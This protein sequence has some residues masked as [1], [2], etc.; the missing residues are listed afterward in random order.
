MNYC[1]KC[2]M[3]SETEVCPMCESKKLREVTPEDYCFLLECER[4]FGDMLEE[5]MQKEA[6]QCALVPCGTGVS[7]F[8]GLP[9]EHYEVYVPYRDYEK[10][11]EWVA[12]F[13][14]T[15]K[16]EDLK[17]KLLENFDKWHILSSFTTRKIR[18]KLKIEKGADVLAY[19]KCCVEK[20]TSIEDKGFMYSFQNGGH[21]LAVE[22]G[23]TTLWFSSESYEILI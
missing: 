23:E 13:S 14:S 9:L 18:K 21:G 11:N 5:A 10:A 20:A 3:L 1:E 4:S 12:F 2:K 8:F 19:L 15:P 17:A 22:I 16:T 6:L 7:T